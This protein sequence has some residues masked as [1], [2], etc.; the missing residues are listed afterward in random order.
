MDDFAVA[1]IGQLKNMAARAAEQ[2]NSVLPGGAGSAIN[3]MVSAWT[4]NHENAQ[5]YAT[6]NLG[7]LKAVAKKF[8]Q[9]LYEA[10]R[11]PAMPAWSA[12][13]GQ[14]DFALANLGQLKKLF[15]FEI[16]GTP[17]DGSSGGGSPT[18]T[19]GSSSGGGSTGTGGSGTGGS[20]T[21][22]SGSSGGGTSTP[23]SPAPYSLAAAGLKYV[24]KPQSPV[25]QSDF[26]FLVDENGSCTPGLGNEFIRVYERPR[27]VLESDHW[28]AV[29]AADHGRDCVLLYKR[30][31]VTDRWLIGGKNPLNVLKLPAVRKDLLTN[32]G[33]KMA[34]HE[35][36]SGDAI[37]AIAAARNIPGLTDNIATIDIWRYKAAASAWVPDMPANQC[38]A[39]SKEALVMGYDEAEYERTHP[40]PTSSISAWNAWLT[41]FLNWIDARRALVGAE[42]P[43]PFELG[44]DGYGDITSLA[45][46]GEDIVLGVPNAI[47]FDGPI[48]P[49]ILRKP[50]KDGE[51][52]VFVLSKYPTSGW[53]CRASLDPSHPTPGSPPLAPDA[54][55]RQFGASLALNERWLCIGASSSDP[56]YVAKSAVFVLPNSPFAAFPAM[57]K[58]SEPALPPNEPALRSFGSS[59]ALMGNVIVVGAPVADTVSAS[60]PPDG[61]IYTFGPG[62]AGTLVPWWDPV[63]I[64]GDPSVGGKLGI[65][66]GNIWTVSQNMPDNW[67]PDQSLASPSFVTYSPVAGQNSLEK[68]SVRRLGPPATA[69]STSGEPPGIKAAGLSPLNAWTGTT[70]FERNFDQDGGQ[71]Q[72]GS[73]RQACKV[74]ADTVEGATLFLVD[75]D[76]AWE[77]RTNVNVLAGFGITRSDGSTISLSNAFHV[78][79]VPGDNL[80]L[81]ITASKP[82]ITL[83]TPGMNML[84]C[85][86]Q[87]KAR[88]V[89]N[90]VSKPEATTDIV[91]P[92]YLQP[93]IQA[94]VIGRY[95]PTMSDLNWQA[96]VNAILKG[97]RD[98]GYFVMSWT[99]GA[100]NNLPWPGGEMPVG[101]SYTLEVLRRDTAQSSTPEWKVVRKD[102][103]TDSYAYIPPRYVPVS[104]DLSFRVSI[105]D[106]D[107]AATKVSNT[108]TEPWDAN[109]NGLPDTWESKYDLNLPAPD[110]PDYAS[111][112]A[113]YV[114]DYTNGKPPRIPGTGSGGG[115]GSGGGDPPP[116]GPSPS[117]C[118]LVSPFGDLYATFRCSDVSGTFSS[119]YYRRGAQ[120]TKTTSARNFS[121]SILGSIL[122]AEQADY[123]TLAPPVGSW[124]T[125]DETFNLFGEQ[126]GGFDA[127]QWRQ[128]QARDSRDQP[129]TY[130]ASMT[131]GI[132]HLSVLLDDPNPDDAPKTILCYLDVVDS[133]QG[134]DAEGHSIPTQHHGG[135]LRFSIPK[136]KKQPSVCDLGGF[137]TVEGFSLRAVKLGDDFA[138]Q[139]TA[140]PPVGDSFRNVKATLVPVEL[141][142]DLNNDGKLDSADAGLVGGAYASGATSD[143]IEKY[144]EFMFID[145]NVS[146]G[147]WDKDESGAPSGSGDDDAEEIHVSV[148]ITG[149]EVWFEHQAGTSLKFFKER[150]CT[151]EIQISSDHHFT[152]SSTNTLPA[153]LFVRAE[154]NLNAPATDPQIEGDLKLMIKPSGSSAKIEAAKLK[155][156]VVKGLGATQHNNA[157]VDYIRERGVTRYM[158]FIEPGNLVLSTFYVVMIDGYADLD[159]I[160]AKGSDLRCVDEVILS[161]FAKTQTVVINGSYEGPGGGSATKPGFY[162]FQ[163]GELYSLGFWDTSASR[164]STDPG[165]IYVA[166]GVLNTPTTLASGDMPPS[167]F[168]GIGGL[169]DYVPN[170]SWS[171]L[172]KATLSHDTIVFA[173]SGLTTTSIQKLHDGYSKGAKSSQWAQ[174]DGGGSTALAVA[175]PDGTMKVRVKWTRHMGASNRLSNGYLAGEGILGYLAFKAQKSK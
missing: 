13:Q 143:Q 17:G 42:V 41:T 147:A 81:A 123:E 122:D 40:Q 152:I 167:S 117:G 116:P 104:R 113:S 121:P 84:R 72:Y 157:A 61:R 78:D 95:V 80:R 148:G 149:G 96:Q 52:I 83:L 36:A 15:S 49:S 35:Q 115:S 9:R 133:F 141:Y 46:F 127:L 31:N 45:V 94:P 91:L 109:N 92:V 118:R 139:V 44:F 142:S 105:V 128:A 34:L 63:Q 70:R 137:P 159:A 67:M 76:T 47:V 173:A 171:T 3:S 156:V 65:F 32:Y 169:F 74:N 77:A 134:T 168:A 165:R 107:N 85:R 27:T 43:Q 4:T 62:P 16:E 90:N 51:G 108:Y 75:C 114:N 30:T 50:G 99:S 112:L 71:V 87:S 175:D 55:C 151:N 20:G 88:V 33:M 132:Q 146:N 59:V 1:N 12:A 89:V 18:G 160:N 86:L 48:S 11:I 101:L 144:T 158:N 125:F 153:Q 154:S 58:L 23:T 100:K 97:W 120:D 124:P 57:T 161:P 21:G 126:M 82:G 79:P 29:Q 25:W 162:D 60:A 2:M 129:V 73:I 24:V 14:D 8:H 7:Q 66:M 22:G 166:G 53:T 131:K 19:G 37:L 26:N 155:L 119:C 163:L 174:L 138:L 6:L 54:R 145:D 56:S 102:L 10:G 68:A 164:K 38:L 135:L 69:F 110:S 130:D 111:T 136:G 140:Q 98:E 106:A 39:L 150:E 5:D 170:G 28:L 64:P 172:A 103:S 93:G